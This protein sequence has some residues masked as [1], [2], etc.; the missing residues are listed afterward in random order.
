MSSIVLRLILVAMPLLTTCDEGTPTP[1]AELP[2]SWILVLT[3]TSPE[4]MDIKEN[5]NR[6]ISTAAGFDEGDSL[7]AEWAVRRRVAYRFRT[8]TTE[9]RNAELDLLSGAI[10][11]HT[12]PGDFPPQ[13]VYGIDDFTYGTPGS[14]NVVD[15]EYPLS[16][17]DTEATTE[18]SF[19]RTF[20]FSEDTT[21]LQLPSDLIS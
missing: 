10:D 16:G 7:D 21:H 13:T 11:Q 15:N 1:K 20:L 3:S 19:P 2:D 18:G 4:M 5:A 17:S 6:R 14:Q 8:E 9:K 12:N